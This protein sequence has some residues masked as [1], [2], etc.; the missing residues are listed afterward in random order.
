MTELLTIFD[1]MHQETTSPFELFIF[2][3][4]F[5]SVF[6]FSLVLI[7]TKMLKMFADI[8]KSIVELK[9]SPSKDYKPQVYQEVDISNLLRDI[10][11]ELSADRVLIL[12][13]HNGEKS[14]ANNPFLKFSCTNELL[15][16]MTSS[17]LRKLSAIPAN[18]LGEWNV[19]LFDGE[20]IHIPHL[21]SLNDLAELRGFY[22]ITKA[23]SVDSLY[24]FPLQT[25][26]GKT[27]GIGIL[28]YNNG[29]RFL[30]DQELNTANKRFASIG[31]LL[32]GVDS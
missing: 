2:T 7:W 26:H 29:E 3:V 1:L 9:D 19:R 11:H 16:T 12:Q 18:M 24:M 13:Y 5:I 25:P 8:R 28:H 21:D 6:L 10:S 22:Q 20:C 23:Q 4:M 32:A 15:N 30:N 31:S 27:Y 14:I 17:V